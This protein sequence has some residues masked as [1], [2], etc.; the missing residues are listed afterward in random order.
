MVFALLLV[1]L[2]IGSGFY[3]LSFFGLL[4]LVPSLISSSRPPTR[5]A[6]APPKQEVR[7]ISPPP[8]QQPQATVQAS[9]PTTMAAP[10]PSPQSPTYSMALFPTSMFPPI[11]QLGT[12]PQPTKETAQRKPEERDELLEVGAVLALLRLALG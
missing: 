2:G 12:I 11:S 10:M 4:L 1:L 6:P 5:P 7:R 8:V 9:Q 3:L